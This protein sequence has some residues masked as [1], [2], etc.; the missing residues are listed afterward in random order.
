MHIKRKRCGLFR[1]TTEILNTDLQHIWIVHFAAREK[2][3]KSTRTFRAVSQAFL[4]VFTI[5]RRYTLDT[6]N[7]CKIPDLVPRL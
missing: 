2:H 1:P 7:S 4:E 6:N 5:Q 3:V